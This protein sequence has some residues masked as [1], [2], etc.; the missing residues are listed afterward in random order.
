MAAEGGAMLKHRKVVP[1]DYSI[2]RMTVTVYT[3]A[4]GGRHILKNVHYEITNQ[5]IV[6]HG[7]ARIQRSFLLVIP[8]FW[9]IRPGDKVV[10]GEGPEGLSWEQL[11]GQI[12]GLTVAGS[13]K[14]RYF[15]GK[16]CHMEVRG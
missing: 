7:A 5:R 16:I 9:D 14:P 15:D 4:D 13:V 6:E 12:N 1:L 3:A 2:C 11:N 8:G 10:L